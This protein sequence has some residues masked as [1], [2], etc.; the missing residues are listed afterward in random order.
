MVAPRSHGP[1]PGVAIRRPTLIS[2][3]VA[4]ITGS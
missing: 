4:F 2:D 3:T 1:F